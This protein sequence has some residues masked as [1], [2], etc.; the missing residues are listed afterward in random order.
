MKV[1]VVHVAFSVQFGE[2]EEIVSVTDS[3]ESAKKIAQKTFQHHSPF[4]KEEGNDVED[5]FRPKDNMYSDE[6]A[7]F[8]Y[9]TEKELVSA[10]SKQKGKLQ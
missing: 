10:I 8:V 1:Y 3:F 5:Y 2:L 7:V 4:Y 6:D 9:I